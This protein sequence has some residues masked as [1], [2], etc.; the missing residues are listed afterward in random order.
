[1]LLSLASLTVSGG[2][3]AL[4]VSLPVAIGPGSRLSRTRRIAWAFTGLAAQL[5]WLVPTLV[6]S[7]S[8]TGVGAAGS[9]VFRLRAES[10]VGALVTALGTGGVWNAEAV[11]GSRTTAL[12]LL[13]T[14]VLLGLAAAGARR[15][16]P[17][18][19]RAATLTLGALAA[20]G[21]LWSVAGTVEVLDPLVTWVVGSV[22]GGGVLRDAQ[23][24]LAPWLVL[25]AVAAGLGADRLARALARRTDRTA[26]RTLLVA[27]VLVPV[28]CLPDAAWGVSGQLASVS[29]PDDY[30]VVRARLAAAGPGQAISLPWQTFRR[31]PWNDGRTVLDPVPRAMTR[32]VVSADSLVV[33]SHG[34]LVVVS[35]ED[36]RSGEVSRA[37]EAGDPLGPV[38]SR[39]GIG[40]AVVA[41][42]VADPTADLPTDAVL[43]S[44]GTHLALYRLRPPQTPPAPSGV[45]GVLVGDLVALTLLAAA[46]ALATAAAVTRRARARESV[47][48]ATGW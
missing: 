43:V 46:L 19:G 24:W 11:P 33:R 34:A 3:L 48:R 6:V 17:V 13:A 30:A 2:L 12:P 42:D 37:I 32:T 1:L 5:P 27:L 39:M 47:D 44:P 26:A 29:Y 22:P 18:L 20:L 14:L 8:V 41:T 36:P 7:S 15:V 9:E 16:V 23:K 31:F 21:L 28:A 40:W 38:L 4:A 45:L 25:L 35:G 10:W